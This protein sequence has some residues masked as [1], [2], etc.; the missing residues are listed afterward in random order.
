MDSFMKALRF[1]IIAAALVAAAA[2]CKKF[3]TKNDVIPVSR[4]KLDYS[5]E[6]VVIGDQIQLHA[7]VE[8]AKATFKKVSWSSSDTQT[9]TV[10]DNGLVSAKKK[11]DATITATAG[12]CEAQCLIHVVNEIIHVTGISINPD[13]I[14]LMPGGSQQVSVRLTPSNATNHNVTWSSGNEEIVTVNDGKVTAVGYG[15]TSIKAV[16][17]D[18]GNEASATVKVVKPFSSITFTYPGTSDSRYNAETGKFVFLTGDEIQLAAKGSPADA[19]DG[20][21]YLIAGWSNNNYRNYC[22]VTPEGLL[23]ITKAYSN[24]TV[25]ARSKADEDVYADL[26]FDIRTKPEG[27]ILKE[28]GHTGITKHLGVGSTHTYTVSVAPTGSP[29]DVRVVGYGKC[30][31]YISGSTLTINVPST[32]VA[33]TTSS[34][35][36]ATVILKAEGGYQQTFTFIISALDPWQAKIGDIID[37][38]G[39]VFDGGYRGNGLKTTAEEKTNYPNSIIAWLGDAHTTEDPFWA[40]YKPTTGIKVNGT[41][42][43]GIAIP[44]NV[45]Q[46]YRKD[47]SSGE[48]YYRDG[49]DNNYI[50]DSGNLP[51][52]LK[53]DTSKQELMKSTSK[54]HSAFMNTCCHV[55]TNAGRGGSWEVIPFNYFYDNYTKKPSEDLGESNSMSSGNY[56]FAYSFR[57]SNVFNA[58]VVNEFNLSGVNMTTWICPT[59]AD[60]YSIFTDYTVPDCSGPFASTEVSS[61]S[62]LERVRERVLLFREVA[63]DYGYSLNYINIPWWVANESGRLAG[64]G[65]KLYLCQFKVTDQYHVI[66]DRYVQYKNDGNRAF[67]FPIRYF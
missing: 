13:N 36:K 60:L 43:H 66:I 25:R 37:K 32:A 8:P 41:P 48:V 63:L 26:K 34:E 6:T 9:A 38:N 12:S 58:Q 29:Q 46:L 35:N 65:N 61:S 21:E 51:K 28:D 23:T 42:I 49:G 53:D 50:L 52:W 2:G 22:D 7:T 27:I 5:E 3:D 15:T 20:I 18:G 57:S 56:E 4:V 19:E 30:T 67:V 33:S 62:V 11:G 24:L 31:A 17:E 47:Y 54:K 1:A 14:V 44:I 39:N 55:Y 10:D 64:D 40:G 59:I 45:S 16:S